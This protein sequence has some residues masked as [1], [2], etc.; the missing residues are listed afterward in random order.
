MFLAIGSDHAGYK[1]KEEI[2]AFL[3]TKGYEYIDYGTNST[4]SVDYTNIAQKLAE[5]VAEGKYKFGILVCGTGVG[6]SIAANKV[7]KIRA[8]L[9]SDCFTSEA[10][11]KHNDS[12]IL[13]IGERIVGPGL[14]C[15]I[16][17]TFLTTEYEGGRHQRRIDLI[18]EIENKYN[19]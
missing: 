7:P 14:A 13:T 16:V 6:M 4:A 8:A 15:K 18:T 19:K 17:E 10:T 5:D 1:L 3:D 11:R 12:N 2:K 9:C